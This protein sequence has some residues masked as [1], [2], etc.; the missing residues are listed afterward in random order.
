MVDLA[1]QR[2]TS[3]GY[4]RARLSRPAK[5]ANATPS[6]SVVIPSYNYGAY[7]PACVASVLGQEGVDLE[8][9]IVDDRSTDGSGEVAESL[10]TADRRV[11]VHHN[12]RNLG[13]IATYNL[14]FSLVS[15]EYVL[16]VSAD[17]M[18]TPGAI[19]RAVTLLEACPSVGF[20][21]GWSLP[22]V[23]G[24]QL[25]RARLRT[26]SWSVWHGED[27]VADRC[28][29]GCNVIRSSDALVRRSVLDEV[30]GYRA[31]LPHSGDFEWWMRAAL[32]ADVGMV[33][34]VD[35][36]YYRLHGAN[37]S[38]TTYAS[39]S[40]NLRATRDAFEAALAD[41]GPRSAN[42]VALLDVA[43]QTLARVA[44]ELATVEF[45]SAS[46]DSV[47]IADYKGFARAT[48][49][50]ITQSRQWRALA[51]RE[52]AGGTGARR[53]PAF[54]ATEVARDLRAKARWRRWRFSGI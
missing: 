8:V 20:A 33:C 35:Q 41:G 48:Y 11:R 4:S 51:R 2:L 37:M 13:H 30:G 27:W 42:R 21:Y 15:G 18:L 3:A 39:T 47:A 36:L 44:V 10:A 54:R 26:R 24:E 17:D 19:A 52:K 29:R 31:D 9:L 43:H 5:A 28:R 32:V 50:A 25:P 14:G 53:N 40:I 1:A 45:M 34:G 46:P 49:P 38:R 12:P 23:E 16:L 22:F 7:L 6:V